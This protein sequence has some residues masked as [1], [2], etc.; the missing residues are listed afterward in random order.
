MT[1]L[2]LSIA[3]GDYDRTR[4]IH[5]G[6]VQIDGVTPIT[7]LLSP[8]EMFFRAF[9]DEAFDI[10][11]LSLSS[12]CVKRARG[13]A[14]YIAVPVFLSRAFRHSAIYIRTDRGITV[15]ADLKGRSIGVAECASSVGMGCVRSALA[16]M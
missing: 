10:S 11:E 14:P 15:P 9:R 7:Q 13:G 12:Y 4:P 1:Y 3:V 6:R 5:D 2:T 8:E 16:G